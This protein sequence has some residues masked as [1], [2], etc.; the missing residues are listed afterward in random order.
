MDELCSQSFIVPKELIVIFKQGKYRKHQLHK[1][2]LQV[3]P[4]GMV[5]QF[6]IDYMHCVCLGVMRK[7]L[8]AWVCSSFKCLKPSNVNRISERLNSLKNE[9]PKDFCRKPRDLKELDRWKATEFRQFLLY[10]GPVVLQNILPSENY[11]NFLK[12]HI[13][14][15]ILLNQS[16]DRSLIGMA[17][18]LL[19]EF[20][21]QC[22]TLYGNQF[23][24]YNIH[25]LTHLAAEYVYFGSLDNVSAFPYESYLY[26]LKSL[27]RTPNKP[28]QQVA[29]R[30]LEIRN[31]IIKK[32]R[33]CN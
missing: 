12:L 21:S 4:I 17:G 3:L 13:A 2:P 7:L 31:C 24:S 11:K 23:L 22:I 28:L 20:V 19:D 15:R 32:F 5:T 30:I 6:P 14:L 1:S 9:V 26:H 27:L 10:T 8:R 18:K 29:R 16:T 33:M 25:A